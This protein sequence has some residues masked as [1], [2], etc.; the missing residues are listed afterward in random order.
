MTN[1]PGTA[2][3]KPII[4]AVMKTALERGLSPADALFGPIGDQRDRDAAEALLQAAWMT[5]HRPR[6]DSVDHMPEERGAL[7]MALLQAAQPGRDWAAEF[8]QQRADYERI[9]EEDSRRPEA[10]RPAGSRDDLDDGIP[11]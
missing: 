11:F 10:A 3:R 2:A 1:G 4:D 7:I 9:S 5:A 6:A 8:A